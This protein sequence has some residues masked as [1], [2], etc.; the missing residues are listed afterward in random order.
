[1]KFANV[2]THEGA[3]PTWCLVIDSPEARD[4]TNQLIN[5]EFTKYLRNPHASKDLLFPVRSGATMR[6]TMSVQMGERDGMYVNHRGGM[7]IHPYKVLDTVEADAFPVD[8][9]TVSY[10][11][12]QNGT[13]WYARLNNGVDVEYDGQLKWDTKAEAEAAS[14]KFLAEYR[15]NKAKG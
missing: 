14:V 8:N 15:A 7:C 9:L 11:Q 2:I 5:S 13:H 4:F 3:E 10:S 6:A 12:W 1:M